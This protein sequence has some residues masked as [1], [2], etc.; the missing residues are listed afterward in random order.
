MSNKQFT[1]TEK[2][3]DMLNL[4]PKRMR[5]KFVSDAIINMFKK[6]DVLANYTVKT[7]KLSSKSQ[8]ENNVNDA[9]NQVFETNENNTKSSKKKSGKIKV[10][11]SF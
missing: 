6:K 10:D 5:S 7:R 4:V 1:I 8:P 11:D 2:A 3:E 9:E